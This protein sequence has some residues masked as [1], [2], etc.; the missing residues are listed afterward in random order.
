MASHPLESDPKPSAAI[1]QRALRN[2]VNT[3]IFKKINGQGDK[4]FVDMIMENIGTDTLDME[5][6]EKI[7]FFDKVR[8]IFGTF[9][10]IEQSDEENRI[11]MIRSLIRVVFPDLLEESEEKKLISGSRIRSLKDKINMEIH[12]LS[13]DSR[14]T[15]F[16]VNRF[17]R[18]ILFHGDEEA[19]LKTVSER[20]AEA[21]DEIPSEV[22]LPL[23]QTIEAMSGKKPTVLRKIIASALKNFKRTQK[24]TVTNPQKIS[25]LRDL[26]G[27]IESLESRKMTVSDFHILDYLRDYIDSGTAENLMGLEDSRHPKTLV[28][29][30]VNSRYN[31]NLLKDDLFTSRARNEAVSGA[32]I[33][34]M[35][36][37]D[38]EE[39]AFCLREIAKGRLDMEEVSLR[40]GIGASP[41]DVPLRIFSYP[42][43]ALLIA[44][45]L[46]ERYGKSPKVDFFTGQEGG[47][48]CN[49]MPEDL[50]RA[51]TR[52]A[53]KLV[54]SFVQTFF[55][56]IADRFSL[57]SD[58]EWSHPQTR[59]MVDYLES[60]LREEA[61][62]GDNSHLQKIVNELQKRGSHYGAEGGAE[63]SLR[64]AAFHTICFRDVPTI[65]A[66]IDGVENGP[67]HIISIGGS[68]EREFDYIRNILARKFSVEGFNKFVQ[69]RGQSELQIENSMPSLETRASLIADT[70]S[71]PPYFLVKEVGDI[72]VSD[73]MRMD[74]ET[75]RELFANRIKGALTTPHTTGQNDER[76]L[77]G[78]R[79]LVQGMSLIAAVTGREPFIDFIHNLNKQA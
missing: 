1:A 5:E 68:S 62:R 61:E 25:D 65:N 13:G 66:Y 43:P 56:D 7:V 16:D 37:R 77:S 8:D 36:K 51:N 78:A 27:F 58:K 64:Y 69:Q 20:L 70:G 15:E 24:K 35:E 10:G 54:N 74:P 55:P 41:V 60:L 39:I 4:V 23:T 30:V 45:R 49:G 53:F 79:S 6:G 75:M 26:M 72:G 59:I 21:K 12:R 44:R 42:I 34:S 57:V 3:I 40:T 67:S 18:D 28:G 9:F 50:V 29:A 31:G 73:T 38:F 33:S 2:V 71:I 17:V 19:D 14:S 22:V 52:D 63:N 11:K 46:K 32:A 47:I 48:A 76:R